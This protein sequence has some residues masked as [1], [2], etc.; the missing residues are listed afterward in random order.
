[1]T[2]LQKMVLISARQCHATSNLKKHLAP[3][4]THL[5]IKAPC[6]TQLKHLTSENTNSVLGTNLGGEHGTG[7]E[8]EKSN[9]RKT[10]KYKEI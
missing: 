9:D 10:L 1:M 3:S 6:S 8:F 4:V 5:S 7:E 2:Q